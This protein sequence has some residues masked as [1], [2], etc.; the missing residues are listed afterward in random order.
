MGD[1]DDA[2]RAGTTFGALT[3]GEQIGRGPLG[4]IYAAADPAGDEVAVE[5]VP[6]EEFDDDRA[7]ARLEA[8]VAGAA[9]LDH[10]GLVRV[11]AAVRTPEGGVGVVRD[12]AAGRTL[13]SALAERGALPPSRVASLLGEVLAGLEA[14]HQAG[15]VHGDLRPARVVIEGERVRLDGLGLATGLDDEVALLG[16]ADPERARYAAPERSAGAGAADARADLYSVG[17]LA[18]EA[19]TGQPPFAARNALELVRLHRHEPPPALASVRAEV[20]GCFE[21]VVRKALAKEPEARYPTAAAF[22]EAVEALPVGPSPKQQETVDLEVAAAEGQAEA[23]GPPGS[24]DELVG[25]LLDGQHRIL[26]KLGEGGW[27]PSFARGAS[28]WG[29]TSR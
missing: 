4:P 6:P 28:C 21:A 23:A 16:S 29:T 15:L 22:R 17:V 2:A 9:A 27:G 8:S 1:M 7:I 12:R 5:V 20:P 26:E 19:L 14:V 11:R 10:P 24:F 3:L 25:S 18:F 13:A